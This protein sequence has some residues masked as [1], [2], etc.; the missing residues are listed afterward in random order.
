M[1]APADTRWVPND[2]DSGDESS[3]DAIRTGLDTTMLVEAGAGSGKTTLMV[4]RLLA[5]IARG[6]PVDQL[7]AVTFTKKAANELRQRL[8]AKVEQN[9][10]ERDGE[11]RE[12]YEVALRDRERM[13]IGTVH[14]FCGRILREY[15]FEA[16]LPPDFTELDEAETASLRESH[17]RSFID[18]AAHD[19]SS[20][21]NDVVSV[22]IDPLTL[23]AA[24]KQREQ[25]RDITFPAPALTVPA[26][27][28]VREVLR[29]LMD[30]AEELRPQTG[31]PERDALQKTIDRLW[32][33]YRL[34]DGWVSAVH[35]AEGARS[36]LTPS[37]RKL[38]QK[39]WGDTKDAKGRA[40]D[41]A[42]ALES[43]VEQQLTLWF[44]KWW[45][46]AYAPA[47]ALLDAGSRWALHQRIR[48]GQLGFDDLLT[49]AASLLRN[50]ATARQAIG[51]RWRYLLVD[52]FQDTDPVQAEV[53]FLIAS[54]SSEGND[55]RTVALRPGSLFV[56]GDPKQ[57]IYRFRRADLAMYQLV[58]QRIAECGTVEH[59][60]RNFRSVPAIGALVNEHFA[61]VFGNAESATDSNS[62]Q[63]PF[64]KFVAASSRT[65]HAAAGISRYRIGK[66]G[67]ESN[68]ALIAEDAALLASWI[69][70]RCA[71]NGDRRPQDFLVLTPRKAE[72]TAYAHELAVRNIPVT[73]TGAPSTVD[74]VLQ[75]LL[76]VLHALADPANPIAVIA[77]LEGWCVGC[78]HA[79]LWEARQLG[80]EFRI[81][82]IPR[83]QESPAGFGLHQLRE[84]WL[85]SQRLPAS[86]LLERVMD[87][88]GLLV[89]AASTE[90]GDTSAGRL[91]QLVATLQGGV[92]TDLGAA[93]EAIEQLL[94]ADDT[95]ATLRPPRADAVRL[96]NLHKAKGLEAPVVVLAAPLPSIPR[97]PTVATWRERGA[98]VGALNVCDDD[99]HTI[100]QPAD[101]EARAAEERARVNAEWDRLLYVAVT[102]AEEELVVS[103]R[104]SYTLQSGE[105]RQ[106]TSRW[107]PLKDVLARHARELQLSADAPVGR[108]VVEVTTEAI[109]AQIVEAE[110]RLAQSKPA[111]YVLISVTEAVKRTAEQ[112][113]HDGAPRSVD[114]TELDEFEVVAANVDVPAVPSPLRPVVDRRTLGTLVH[115]ALEAAL[116][117]R[118]GTELREYAAALVWHEVP[119]ADDAKR[120]ELLREILGAVDDAKRTESWTLLTSGANRPL[121]ELNV[122][123]FAVR[124][125]TAVLT[126]GVI[127][128]AVLHNG[129]WVVVD[130]K[131]NRSSEPV[132]QRL[133]EVYQQQAASYVET[134]QIRTAASGN[135]RI[136]RLRS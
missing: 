4:D 7:A 124:A 77:A 70:Q 9:A 68:A 43:F 87:E 82:H 69:A 127:D 35:F 133:M 52:E 93:I 125:K 74:D 79:D 89:L 62:P 10:R 71:A 116:R 14:A 17:W 94:S 50:N 109:R 117:G 18:H 61:S 1:S 31:S 51:E 32:R 3:R 55:W 130:W 136:E 110:H 76:V 95:S 132:W 120:A 2:D 112:A 104:A 99:G 67:K 118:T 25:Y 85:A 66:V 113:E 34:H 90:L 83:E 39:N 40:K 119:E 37:N 81:T 129:E 107:S 49:E 114:S 8:E 41:F 100:A 26:H 30:L 121:P 78:S 38:T 101:W 58:Q 56:V 122:A 108:Q 5:Y 126:E 131:L 21:L 98:G 11:I 86:T 13:F 27:E 92:G 57:S 80:L 48:S 111:R 16:G 42:A 128:A 22:G 135:A 97:E 28:K 19:N 123:N 33:S 53:C 12:R 84:W 59:L 47:I 88:S 45:A 44:Q 96:M 63:A 24:V 91:L 65:P 75:E 46:H 23:F 15:A 73:V 29:G 60:T 54:E 134:L 102:R 115:A 36:L 106:D 105:T 6:T 20:L 103:Q 64:A 72:L